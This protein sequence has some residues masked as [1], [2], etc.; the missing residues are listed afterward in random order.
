[1]QIDWMPV[2]VS[3]DEA[4]GALMPG[5]AAKHGIIGRL[6]HGEVFLEIWPSEPPEHIDDRVTL[7]LTVDGAIVEEI[8]RFSSHSE[9][10][11]AAQEYFDDHA[12][13]PPGAC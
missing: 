10:M 11:S 5:L 9:A 7:T 2:S 12:G 8:G 1:M 6:G 4:D 3:Y 13:Q